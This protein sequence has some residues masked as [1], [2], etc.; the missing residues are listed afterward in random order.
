MTKY[1]GN[2]AI[3]EESLFEAVLSNWMIFLGLSLYFRLDSTYV[4]GSW[5]W[6]PLIS[7]FLS[8]QLRK[9]K[10]YTLNAYV[11]V[12][13]AGF[14]VPVCHSMQVMSV[15]LQFFFP[16]MGRSGTSVPPDIA[17]G[18]IVSLF[19]LVCIFCMVL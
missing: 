12:Y 11:L 6:C 8:N 2:L 17:I 16:L 10:Y 5:V 14:V 19:S 1:S 13:V 4:I 7:R 3:R 15:G 18:I 9:T